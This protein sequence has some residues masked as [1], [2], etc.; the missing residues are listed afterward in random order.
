[1]GNHDSTTK[2]EREEEHQKMLKIATDFYLSPRYIRMRQ[3]QEKFKELRELEKL[4]AEHLEV[5]RATF[6]L[7]R[8][9]KVD[10]ILKAMAAAGLDL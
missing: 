9:T 8:D 2:E 6:W 1:M 4:E 5:E 7:G 10:L 3:L